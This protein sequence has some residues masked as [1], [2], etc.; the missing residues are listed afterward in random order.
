MRIEFGFFFQIFNDEEEIEEETNSTLVGFHLDDA[1]E[2][3]EE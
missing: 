3:D 2:F 1:E